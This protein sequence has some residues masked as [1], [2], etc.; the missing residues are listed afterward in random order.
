MHKDSSDQG[1]LFI[2]LFSV[3][4]SVRALNEREQLTFDALLKL[5]G[6]LIRVH[7]EEF[8]VS[9]SLIKPV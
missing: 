5:V 2:R 6:H 3:N 4:Y 7:F 8:L 1:Q 9:L